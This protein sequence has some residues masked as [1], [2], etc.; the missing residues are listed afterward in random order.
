MVE[1]SLAGIKTVLAFGGQKKILDRYSKLIQPASRAGI[2]KGAWSGLSGGF[3]FLIIF[4]GYALG[5]WYGIK[6]I[7]DE[8]EDEDCDPCHLNP[9]NTSL[10]N[11]HYQRECFLDCQTYTPEKLVIVFFCIV[12]GAWYLGSAAPYFENIAAAK[13]AAGGVFKIIEQKPEI[14]SFSTTG[15]Q[16]K[17]VIGNI[18]F[19]NVFFNYPSRPDVKILRGLTLD[20]P[21]GKNKTSLEPPRNKLQMGSVAIVNV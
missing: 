20:I 9:F 13:A 17:K 10:E 19:R 12:Y 2:L 14:D 21:A 16:P 4:H 7:L 6:L 15:E 1:E 8:I 18:T 3:A 11:A 5:F